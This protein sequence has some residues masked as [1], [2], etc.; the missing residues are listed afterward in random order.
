MATQANLALSTNLNFTLDMNSHRKKMSSKGLEK[1][2]VRATA[3]WR[4]PVKVT[5]ERLVANQIFQIV[6]LWC[7]WLK[8][9][10][11]IRTD[12]RRGPTSLSILY[13]FLEIPA[14][15]VGSG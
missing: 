14:A 2:R 15:Q 3:Q 6:F 4:P 9:T 13:T 11:S 10:H 8:V 1:D 12:W 7:R 5:Q